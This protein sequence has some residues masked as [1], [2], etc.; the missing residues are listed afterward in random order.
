MLA[1]YWIVNQ[2]GVT[3]NAAYSVAGRIN[4]FA[5]MPAM[6]FSAALST[7][8][9]QNLGANRPD[10]VRKGFMATLKMTAAISLVITA[11]AVFLG[12]YLMMLFTEDPEVIALGKDYLIIVGA[13]YVIFSSMFVL[14][15]ILR[16]A[17]DTMIPMIITLLSLWVFRVPIAYV[18]AELTSIGLQGVFWSIPIGWFSGA[19]L[20]YIYYKA[21]RWKSKAVVKYNTDGDRE[22]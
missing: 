3:A 9:G 16:G 7:F 10:R 11:V 18:L 6:S 12:E 21:G 2:F 14:N 22:D 5:M 8:V 17:G 4:S 13:F 20:A 1:L 15:G 19:V